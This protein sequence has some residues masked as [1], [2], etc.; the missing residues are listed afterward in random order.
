MTVVT[1]WSNFFSY[2][3]SECCL[4][5]PFC[6]DQHDSLGWTYCKWNTR[7]IRT[8]AVPYVEALCVPEPVQYKNLRNHILSTLSVLEAN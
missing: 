3:I 5:F 8:Y 1:Q 6:P 2:E 4:S 7:K